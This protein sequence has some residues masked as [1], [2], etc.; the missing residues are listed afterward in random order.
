VEKAKVAATAPATVL[1][2]GESGTGKELFAHAIHNAGDR[3][4]GRF[5]RVNCASL[6]GGVLESELFGY[7]DGAFTGARKGGRA[8]LFEEADGGTIFLDEVGL[9]S[10]DTQ[11]KL[12]RV[13]QEREVRRVGGTRT[14][15]IDVRVIAAT[16]FDLLDAVHDGSFR[17]DLFYRLNVIPVEIPALRDHPEDIVHL[18]T[19]LIKRINQEY[20][21]AVNSVSPTAVQRLVRYRWPGNI[22]ELENVLRRAIINLSVYESVITDVHLPELPRD[23]EPPTIEGCVDHPS[24]GTLS[25]VLGEA[26]SAHIARVLKANSNSRTRAAAA[27][28]ISLRSLQYKLKKHGL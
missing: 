3:A 18:I 9:M 4:G 1:L 15:P 8:G 6:S 26:E 28:G 21:R 7:E 24:D 23:C 11:A 10:L 17:E 19:H 13:L 12:L 20:G 2:S 14:R 25:E 5:V 22:R 27:L 16:N